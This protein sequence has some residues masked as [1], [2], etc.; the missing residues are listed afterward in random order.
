MGVPGYKSR[1]IDKTLATLLVQLPAVMVT[2]PRAAGKTTTAGRHAVNI[3]RLDRPQEAAAFRADPDVALGGY[4]EPILLDEWQ[5]VPSVLGAVKRAVDRD[6]RPNRFVLTGSVRADLEAATWPGTGRIV[7]VPMYGMTV[8][9]LAGKAE[10]PSLLDRLAS[11]GPLRVPDDSPDLRGY[12]ELALRGGFPDPALSTSESVRARWLEGYVEQLLT[13]DAAGIDSRRDPARLRRY[14]EA[15]ALNTAG[16]VSDTTL[17]RA[18]GINRRTAVA[19]EQLLTNLF[20][21]EAMPAWTSNRL[22]RL[23]LGPKRYFVDPAIPAAVLHLDADAVLRDGDLFG[24]LLDTFVAAQLRAECAS[25]DSRPRL[26]H[27]REEHGRREVDV[28]AEFGGR[29]L[30][31]FEVK[32]DAAPGRDAARHLTWLRDRLGERFAGGIVFHTGPRAFK[33]DEKITAAPISML[34]G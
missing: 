26:Y 2:G 15:Y 34:W 7:R 30:L 22:R 23:S 19:Y 24:R 8:R 21:V 20:V 16:I 9:E 32:A 28:L 11:G 18:A 4:E 12:V 13:R 14:F 1:L 25:S 29:D 5:E 10:G 17:L 33:L 31:A 3:V 6:P 27:L